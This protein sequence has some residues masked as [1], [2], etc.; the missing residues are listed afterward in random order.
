MDRYVAAYW[1][2]K[3]GREVEFIERWKEFTSWSTENAAGAQSFTL[4][5]NEEMPQ[6]FISFGTWVDEE[7]IRAW[8]ELPGFMERYESVQSV[9]E[10][11]V[12]AISTL[13]A[14]LAPAR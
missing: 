9:C 10:E 5:H 6:Y 11:H 4:L 1:K 14:T 12:G 13:E 8:W 3:A 7:S 2:V